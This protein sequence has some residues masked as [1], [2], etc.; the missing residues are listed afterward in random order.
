MKKV[1]PVDAAKIDSMMAAM[2]SDSSGEIDEDEWV[3]NLDTLPDLKAALSADIDPDT[4]RL[5]S[6]RSPRQQF[7]KLL[8]N[9]DR[10][11]Y[12]QSKGKDVAEELASRRKQADRC[13]MAGIH[14]SAGI[15]VFN[16]LDKKKTGN[17]TKEQLTNLFSKMAYEDK[18]VEDVMSRLD[19][20]QDGKIS[21]A[22][23][24]GGLDKVMTLKEA[25][26]KDIDP[27]T[28][29]L[30]SLITSGKAIF[31]MLRRQEGVYAVDK[32]EV[33][34]YLKAL[35]AVFK[36]DNGSLDFDVDNAAD[37]LIEAGKEKMAPAE[38][39]ELLG[40]LPNLDKA[41]KEDY[42]KDR[43][44][45]NS[46]RSCGQQLSKLLGNLDRLRY[47]ERMGEDC[48]DEIASRKQQVK[49]LRGNGILPSPA[50][51]VF[52]QIDVDKSGSITSDE[53]S[54]LM[55]Q[56][57]AVYNVAE[58]E[59]QMMQTLDSND[60]GE[61][62]EVEWCRNL[63]SL[64]G[65]K[66]ALQKDLDP[67]TGR[68]KSFRSP[69]QQFAK[70]LANIDRL[71]YDISR[72][73][74]VVRN[75]SEL[76]SRR[77]AANRF[78]LS[79]VT[80]SAGIVVF[81]QIDKK[82]TGT[83]TMA[84]VEKLFQKME[85][86]YKGMVGGKSAADILE[87]LD[88]DKD[89]VVSEQEWLDGLDAVPSLKGALENDID[90]E[91]G[92]LKSLITSGKAIFDMLRRQEGTW[93]V[94]KNEVARYLNAL[95]AVYKPGDDGLKKLHDEYM[96]AGKE[97]L[98]P[99][100]WLEALG[101]MP[102]LDAALKADY[103][104]D[105][106]RF[107]R[108]VGFRSCGQQLSKLLGNLDRLRYRERAGE[109]VSEEIESRKKQVKK[110]RANGIV[111]S[112]GLCVYN[113][114]D[115][116]KSG[117]MDKAEFLGLL[118]VLKKIFPG[119]VGQIDKLLET[120]DTDGDGEISVKEWLDNLHK[121][122]GLKAALQRD[123]DPATGR[124]KSFRTPRQQF[125]KLL[126]NIDRLEYDASKG[127]D[128]TAELESRRK[129]AQ[130][131][132]VAGVTPSAGVMIFEQLDKKKTRKITKEQLQKLFDKMEFKDKSV[133]EVMS[134]LD[135]DKDGGIDHK[136]WLDG[137]DAVPTLKGALE[138]EMDPETGKL[139][140]LITSGRAVF[141]MLRRQEGAY[142]VDKKEV[143][144]F[145]TA[146]NAVFK[147][148]DTTAETAEKL[149]AEEGKMT[150]EEWLELLPSMPTLDAKLKEDFDSD[151]L[152]FKSFRSCGQQLSKLLGNLDRL[153]YKLKT[154]SDEEKADIEAKIASRKAQAKKMRKNGILPSPAVSVFIQLDLDKSGSID[155]AEFKRMLYSLRK[156]FPVGEA[157]VEQMIK[158][159]DTDSSG[160]IE[161]LE[162]VQ[163]LH[164][165]PALKAALVKDLDP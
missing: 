102:N 42:D 80:P 1:F 84:Q 163:N 120:L 5:R 106:V 88:T 45:F 131:F 156:V 144:R 57:R 95:N 154:A 147:P 157:E 90:P 109:N 60:D 110:L 24:L 39:L 113:Q 37:E 138:K 86:N 118:S 91:T 133:E 92:K 69:R 164:K 44:R 152:R 41:L 112:A 46:F 142:A 14:P 125:A 62:S 146:L 29:K 51:S 58:S 128:V 165:L 70:L 81:S 48:A 98:T 59:E 101:T 137:L 11:E 55:S 121:C 72:G 83:I 20:D 161:E 93:A 15:V 100:E 130:R 76:D 160:E 124:L 79:G 2:D 43:V 162:W 23:W 49:K 71:E 34:R 151:R 149:L 12:D 114:V 63:A 117:S 68:L 94:D 52:N 122:P 134:R 8:G 85:E 115:I 67:D 82:K 103:D 89:G 21:E 140:C 33:G 36:P 139:K 107:G 64:P 78:R 143:G 99:D 54:R 4:G 16:Q 73:E 129:Q 61:I 53:L 32:N 26:Q 65:L 13:R 47:R 19:T 148:E 153:R 17:I 56:L 25:L 30:K 27:E 96:A 136:E 87:K 50:L 6:Y 155:A 104:K 9:I 150:P 28:G 105:R 10:L 77:E 135:A 75:Q 74:H 127:K 97:K 159:M 66:M 3:R 111:P 145:L 126:A 141:D 108:T 22:E 31:D 132:R 119:G 40:T 7:A 158:D 116:D 123:L 35:N 38:W 18:S